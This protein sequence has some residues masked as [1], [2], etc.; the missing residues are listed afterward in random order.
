MT[1]TTLTLPLA[2]LLMLLIVG[3]AVNA[4]DTLIAQYAHISGVRAGA[5]HAHAA[6]QYARAQ[7]LRIAPRAEEAQQLRAP[8]VL[9]NVPQP[10]PWSAM[11]GDNPR[12]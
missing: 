5:V 7:M 9:G 1:E 12:R 10:T 3:S 8:Y 6:A 11:E 4:L 2:L